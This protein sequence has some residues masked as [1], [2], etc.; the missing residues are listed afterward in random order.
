MLLNDIEIAQLWLYAITGLTGGLGW[1]CWLLRS[2]IKE[3]KIVSEKLD[4][5][6][7]K[8]NTHLDTD[9]EDLHRNLAL[10]VYK[11]AE[12][13]GVPALILTRHLKAEDVANLNGKEKS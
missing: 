8:L 1:A 10:V 11:I 3:R 5:I 13:V 4:D 12:K 2:L 6:L 9:S 7:S